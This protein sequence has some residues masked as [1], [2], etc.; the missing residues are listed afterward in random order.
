MSAGVEG[1]AR[2]ADGCE[3]AY[4]LH[5]GTGQAAPR[6]ALIHSLALDRRFWDGV[7]A[8]LGGEAEIL[9][10][11]CRGHGRSGRPAGPYTTALFA[12]DLA[13]LFDHLGWTAATVAGCSMG[14]CVAQAFGARHTARTV[15]LGLIDTTAWYGEKAPAEW[16][17]RAAKA[18]AEGLSGLAAFQATRWFGD[19]FRAARPEVVE[20]TTAIFLANDLD[21]YAATCAMLGDA[22]LRP[23]LGALCMPV[24]V[25]V[26]EEDYATTPAM[27][28]AIHE[29]VPG[30]TL[31]VL[32]GARHLTPVETPAAIAAQ[33]R[34]LLRGTRAAAA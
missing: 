29:A 8:E 2:A 31:T 3:I 16:R 7:V 32:P 26:G 14:G 12:D 6:L 9:A 1:A 19:A 25:V 5:R 15:A 4:T 24:A 10:Y 22:D 13:A 33:I 20:A 34:G 11:D 17:E 30:S 21:A 28:R 18:Q 23:G 27:A